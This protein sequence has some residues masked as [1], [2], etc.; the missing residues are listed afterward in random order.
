MAA[1]Q[2]S[3]VTSS[4]WPSTRVYS[5]AGTCLIAG[6]LFGYV[7]SARKTHP[8]P[9]TASNPRA[10]GDLS[11]VHPKLTIEQ[12][13]KMADMRV[14]PLLARLKD[15]PN[16]AALLTQVGDVYNGAH[17]F[18]DA[19][20]YY[21]KSLRLDSKN[22][23]T[24]VE[25]ASC[26]YYAGDVDASLEQLDLAL[27]TNPKDV[28]SLFNLGMIRWKGKHDSARAIAVWQQL[29]DQNP[30]LDRKPIVEQMISE[31][32]SGDTKN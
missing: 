3:N 31:A 24:R 12:M 21:E 19:A 4:G 26:L 28:N 17:R 9:A 15:T 10:M 8:Y 11:G 27:K 18:K 7:I 1:N 16:D 13:R 20:P 14:A 30:N 32:K 25:L 23:G 6:L 22:V 5:L 2:L 29:L